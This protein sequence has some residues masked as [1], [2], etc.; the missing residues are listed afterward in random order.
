M[1]WNCEVSPRRG[2]CGVPKPEQEERKKRKERD[3]RRGSAG[4][5]QQERVSRRGL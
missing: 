2:G 5:G 4:E 3:S 1:R